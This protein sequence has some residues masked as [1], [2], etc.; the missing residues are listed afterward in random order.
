MEYEDLTAPDGTKNNMG[1]ATSRFLFAPL[2]DFL[3]IKTPIAVPVTLGDLVKIVDPHTFDVGKGFLRA[4]CT[5]DRGK[6]ELKSQGDRDGKSFRGEGEFF[7]PGNLADAHG[8]ADQA[9]NDKFIGLMEVPDSA[10]NG[11]L[12]MGNEMFPMSIDPEFTIG[13][14]ASGTRGYLFKFSF[15]TDKQYLYTGTV[16]LKP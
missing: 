10:D 3:L 11:Y 6:Y 13:T 9:K 1:G 14:N 4:Y 12:Q 16:T 7:F 15:N 5:E 2:T 8:L